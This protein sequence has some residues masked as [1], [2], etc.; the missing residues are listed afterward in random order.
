MTQ[1]EPGAELETLRAEYRRLIVEAE[2]AVQDLRALHTRLAQVKPQRGPKGP[3]GPAADLAPFREAFAQLEQETRER[4]DALLARVSTPA[5]VPVPEA[6]DGVP[7]DDVEE[8]LDRLRRETGARVD[9]LI[10][11]ARATLNRIEH[12]ASS[13]LT[14]LSVLGRREQ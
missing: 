12:Q 4:I 14:A 5:P 9:A 7:P 10:A 11:E 3:P 13:A 6:Q 2:Q 8:L 1:S